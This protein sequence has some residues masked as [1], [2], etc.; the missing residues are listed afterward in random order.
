MYE[1]AGNQ[2]LE[3]LLAQ[4]IAW[5]RALHMWFH[6]AHHVVRGTSFSGD[7]AKLYDKIYTSIQDE[8]DGA[9]EKG[10]GLTG[11][12][13]LANPQS[14]AAAALK[15]L[16]GGP[17]PS[18]MDPQQL[19]EAGM[20]LEQAYLSFI[21]DMFEE[22]EEQGMLSLGLNDQLAASANTHETFVYLLGQR[23]R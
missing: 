17:S 20:A 7:H 8:V 16:K 14:V 4:R 11:N 22:L 13:E 12:M 5:L 15:I 19:A 2:Q 10:I 1:Y 3:N 18:E 9:V 23:A 21:S 6:A